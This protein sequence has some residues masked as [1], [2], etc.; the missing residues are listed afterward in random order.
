MYSDSWKI[1]SRKI[2]GKKVQSSGQFFDLIIFQMSQ[3]EDAFIVCSYSRRLLSQTG[4][5]HYSP[6]GGYHSGR[7]LVLILDTARFKYPPHWV[8]L[9]T[10]WEA[11]LAIDKETG[12]SRGFSLVQRLDSLFKADS[13]FMF[14][15]R[16]GKADEDGEG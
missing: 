5:G 13:Q 9:S 4:D 7:D 6:I 15:E 11:M 1:Q 10:L 14:K 16:E 3:R 8:P 12:L 2:G